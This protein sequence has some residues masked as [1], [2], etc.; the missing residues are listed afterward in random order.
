MPR[1][2]R[3]PEAHRRDRTD[4]RA[5]SPQRRGGKKALTPGFVGRS[6]LLVGGLDLFVGRFVLFLWDIELLDEWCYSVLAES[7][8]NFAARLGTAESSLN[9]EFGQIC[10]STDLKP[11]H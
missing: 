3:D 2:R 11:L 8:T 9:R 1:E 7:R 5:G 6:D 10:G 4:R